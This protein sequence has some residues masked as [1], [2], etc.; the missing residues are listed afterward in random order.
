M[1]ARKK[2]TNPPDRH[3]Q[4]D[5][6]PENKETH[7][8]TAG[9]PPESAPQAGEEKSHPGDRAAKQ[10]AGAAK[11]ETRKRAPGKR[12]RK[13][14]S[15]DSGQEAA[16]EAPP[17]ERPFP[18]VGVGA[19]A[20]GLEA[21]EDFLAKMPDNSDLALVVIS[22][23]DPGR[24][25][26]L[27]DI[28]GRKASMPVVQVKDGM[29]VK[30]N[31]VFLPPSN[32]DLILEGDVFHLQEQHRGSF[33]RLPIDTFLK[34]LADA[35]GEFAGCVILSGTG[36]DGTQGLRVIKEK[37]GVTMVQSIASAKYEGMPESAMNTGMAD[38][39]LA[40]AEMPA[41]LVDYFA[42]G[43]R[44]VEAREEEVQA[45]F[46][47]ILSKIVVAISSRT[48]HDFSQ[49]KKST[50][51][52]RIQRRMSVA[53]C[54]TPQNYLTYLHHNPGEIE[55]LFQDLLIGV[56]S[57]FRDPEA[58]ELLSQ[59]ILGELL[60]RDR[61]Q[62]FRV[63]VPGCATGEE[64]YSL[65]ILILE[66]LNELQIRREIQVFGTDIDR[67]AIDKARD[68]LYPESIAADVSPERLQLFFIKEN[69]SYRIRKEVREPV[70]FAVQ[71]LL[72]DPPFSRLDLL[73]CRNLLIYLEPKAQ[74][75]ILPLF[76]YSL[77]PGGALFLGSSETVG[78]FSDLFSPV[79]K[80]WNIYRKVD[81]SPGMLPRVEFPAGAKLPSTLMEPRAVQPAPARSE[82]VVEEATER[83]LL[84]QHTPACVVVNRRGEISYI[85]G[86]TGKYLEPAPGRISVNVADMAREGLRFELTAA[87]R[88][89]AGSGEVIHR[90]GLQVKTNG[91]MQEINLT[92]RPLGEAESVSD[93]ILILF[94]DV[95]HPPK[96]ERTKK[97]K[98]A[99]DDDTTRIVELEG[100]LSRIQQD[101]RT[102]MEELET[103]NEELKSVNEELQSSNEE[104]QST[105]E[106]LESSREELQS[107]NEELSTVNAELHDK[108]IELS[109]AY[110]TITHVLNATRIA[111]VFV[112]KNLN[113]RRFTEEATNIINV[114]D[115]D[116]GRPLTH[117]S[118][119]LEAETLS[120]DIKKSIKE[121][122]T[123]EKR[124]KTH[125]GHEY[126][127]RIVPY[128][129]PKDV[130]DGAIL[131][132]INNTRE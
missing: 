17:S 120:E 91:G 46:P 110:D 71:N 82:S 37:G 31:T 70:V 114:I 87:I 72:K 102:A 75:K 52:R 109:Q 94:E 90:A 61:N 20:G 73:V 130:I 16:R 42:S 115:K 29:R 123:I 63:W 97:A 47:S 45:D 56:T 58:F 76:H 113:I 86:R 101:H 68:G 2:N 1:A 107:L 14:Q 13:A 57:F 35:R 23:T 25:S 118:T 34:S 117:I 19:S 69:S 55:A 3:L 116:L 60:N 122:K 77:K 4:Q 127:M 83:L 53:R 64:V 5:P 119:N 62:P 124:V 100:E 84:R 59:H 93:L 80:K 11:A 66:R 28:L 50:L 78:E 9:Q 33:F 21:L 105:N 74:K 129:N 81:S 12:T 24:T 88:K 111:I 26:M 15:A 41:R 6:P 48:G 38:F 67:T 128:S 44:L 30:P 54:R 104:L 10:P 85:H 89:V 36:T 131:T 112:D 18:V 27:P 96:T 32:R 79:Y 65:I 40:P 7:I 8:E 106:E 22:H 108:I 43:I 132:F 99:P 95:T 39:I 103:S 121:L 51:V 49:Y 92:V 125:D 126:F 98:G